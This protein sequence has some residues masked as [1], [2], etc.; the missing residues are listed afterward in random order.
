L[1]QIIDKVYECN[2]QIVIWLID[3]MQAF[4]SI[5]RHKMINIAIQGIHKKVVRLIRV[6]LEEPQAKVVTENNL[7]ESY[8]VD[9]GVRQGDALSV[10]VFNFVLG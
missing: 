7:P 3:F 5:Y 8:N 2:T 4:D 10:I 1:R 6:T 9:V